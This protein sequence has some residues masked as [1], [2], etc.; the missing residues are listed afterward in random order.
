MEILFYNELQEVKPSIKAQFERVIGYLEEGNFTGADVKKLTPHQYL[1]RAKLNDTDRLLFRIVTYQGRKCL[2]ILE[3]IYNHAYDKSRFLQGA[4]IDESKIQPVPKPESVPA[5]DMTPLIYSNPKTKVFHLLDKPISFDDEQEALLNAKLP[6][7]IVGSA[8]SGK[9]VLS[10][11][12]LKYLKGNILYV[13]RSPYLAENASRLYSSYSYDNPD[14][15]IN[16]LSLEDVLLSIRAPETRELSYWE[17]AMWLGKNRG[18]KH[19]TFSVHSLYEEFDGV[20]TGQAGEA[21]CLTREEYMALGIKQSIFPLEERPVIYD[22]FESFTA[23]L[24]STNRHTDNF[25]CHEYLKLAK[26]DYDYL[27]IDEI[28]DLTCIQLSLLLRTLNSPFH[29]MLCGDSNQ[30][31]HPNFF[32]WST[33]KSLFYK[34]HIADRSATINVLHANYRNSQAVTAASNQL[35]RWKIARFGSIDRESNHLVQ[36]TSTTP[37]SITLLQDSAKQKQELNTSTEGSV[38]FAV[39]VMKDEDKPLARAFFKTPLLFS[40]RE[41]KG[42][43]YKNI[44]IFNFISPNRRE[45]DVIAEGITPDKLKTAPEYSRN[46]DKSDRSLELYKFYIN[47]LYVALTRAIENIYWVETHT[48]HPTYRLLGLTEGGTH[49]SLKQQVSSKEEW[50]KEAGKLEAQG[51]TEQAE[52]IRRDVL[53]TVPVPWKV[54]DKKGIGELCNE[55]LQPDNFNA[56]AKKTLLNVAVAYQLESIQRRLVDLGFNAAADR[57]GAEANYRSTYLINYNRANRKRLLADVQRYGVDFRDPF[58]QTPLMLAC[59]MGNAEIVQE[60]LDH[61]A[62][63]EL[64]DNQGFSAYHFLLRQ[65]A[66]AP[67]FPDEFLP[68]ISRLLPQSANYRIEGLQVKYSNQ[69]A[70]FFIITYVMATFRKRCGDLNEKFLNAVLNQD[71]RNR[72]ANTMPTAFFQLLSLYSDIGFTAVDLAEFAAKLPD[73]ILPEHRKKRTYLSSLLSRH[74]RESTNRYGKKLFMRVE[75]GLYILNPHLKVLQ[76]QD[77]DYWD[78]CLPIPWLQTIDGMQ[79]HPVILN[80]AL[81]I[82]GI[83]DFNCDTIEFKESFSLICLI[84]S[85]RFIKVLED[86]KPLFKP[87]KESQWQMLNSRDYDARNDISYLGTLLNAYILFHNSKSFKSICDKIIQIHSSFPPLRDTEQDF[88]KRRLKNGMTTWSPL[89]V[90]A[91]QLKDRLDK[92]KDTIKQTGFTSAIFARFRETPAF[93]PYSLII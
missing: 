93:I 47:A 63:T 69:R 44:I 24:K 88:V 79:M 59:Q 72:E 85:N 16:F 41:A 74:E 32:S 34:E 89:Y 2:L 14:Q 6:L 45:F 64:I 56:K 36:C 91:E 38:N 50:R 40:I 3:I 35:L 27:V 23:W 84:L 90:N 10:L 11:E 48:N 73:F 19:A 60:L 42:L 52:Q 9:T 39:L 33:V 37:G 55:A 67:R 29:F 58:N 62:K 57:K 68:L 54:L 65:I 75:R 43:E 21:P 70:E 25:L 17:F 76:G 77:W 15:E 5:T 13:T 20:L 49:V 26:A 1:Y 28:Q 30:I 87:L 61:D 78:K 22:L 71:S 92:V 82:N 46:K 80:I 7:I 83:R 53:K 12:K 66:A 81:Y 51:K 86:A 8:G 31:V 18:G 4:Q